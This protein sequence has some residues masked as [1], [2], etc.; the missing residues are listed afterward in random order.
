VA[1]QLGAATA[2][3][4]TDVQAAY[5]AKIKASLAARAEE[6]RREK[7][8]R[9]AKFTAGQ[10]AYARGQYPR[11]VQLLE[12]AL[13]EEGPF[14]QVGGEIQLWLALAYNACGREEECVEVYRVLENTHP[15][16][17]IRKQ[18]ASLRYII[19]APKL[20]IDPDER[21]A[22]PVLTDLDPNRGSRQ[23]APRARPAP[24]PK[25]PKTWDEEYWTNYQPPVYLANRYVWAAAA[26]VAAGLALFSSR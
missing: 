1:R 15:A 25:R 6:L 19:E 23:P 3:Q 8:A 4:L 20:E 9:S 5:K 13:N 12:G 11:S 17:A 10:A 22:I 24:A 16:P 18:A 7:E 26:A 2:A 21:V 14:S